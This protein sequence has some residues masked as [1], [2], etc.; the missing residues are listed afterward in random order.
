LSGVPYVPGLNS[1]AYL[2]VPISS[3]TCRL[4]IA[5]T[6]AWISRCGIDGSNIFTFGPKSG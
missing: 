3:S 4:A 2:R 6:V 1:N 5:S